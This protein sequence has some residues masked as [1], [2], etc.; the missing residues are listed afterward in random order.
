MYNNELI[1]L[2]GLADPEMHSDLAKSFDFYKQEAEAHPDFYE[3]QFGIEREVVDEREFRVESTYYQ[4]LLHSYMGKPA[5]ITTKPTDPSYRREEWYYSGKLHRE[6]GPARTIV[7]K[8]IKVEEWYYD[9]KLHRIGGPAVISETYANNEFLGKT[10]KWYYDGKFHREDGP[11]NIAIF[12]TYST[13]EWYYDGKNTE[14][15]DL[16]F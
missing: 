5:K 9:D 2:V 12:P 11:A 14:Q 3:K 13:Q 7:S 8:N 16:L 15:M 1:R 10:E 4:G 6:N